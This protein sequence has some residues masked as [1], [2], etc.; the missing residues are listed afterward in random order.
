MA[1]IHQFLA[2]F[3]R[4]D[5]ISNEAV[6]LRS[7]FRSWG[8]ESEIFSEVRRIPPE[9]RGEAR[10]VAEY[11]LQCRSDDVVVLHLSIGSIVNEVF[12]H[13]RCRKAILYHNV[14]PAHYMAP[15][16]KQIAQIL[17]R[18]E[19][20]VKDLAGIA[21]VNMADSRFNADELAEIGYSNVK[22][23]PL[24]LDYSKLSEKPDR[25]VLK[26]FNDDLT[27]ILFVGRCAPNKK[28]ED[29][30][31]AFAYFQRNVNADSRFVHVGSHAGLE[32]YYYALKAMC[33]D[34]KLRNVHFAGTTTQSELNAFYRSADIF[35]CMSEHEGFC[36]PV[37]ESMV[38][39]VPVMAY[40][41]GAVPET[42]DGSGILFD[43]KDFRMIAEMMG[44]LTQ[45]QSLRSSV[46]LGQVERLERYRRRDLA[47]ELRRHL[48]P[49]LQ[50]LN[51]SPRRHQSTKKGSN[52][53]IPP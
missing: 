21:E 49:L 39:N 31:L 2:G 11:E 43:N 5:A 32:R 52:N 19:Q 17:A 8:Y 27:T 3:N 36:I 10:D 18:G 35:L 23:L 34:W 9:L 40:A 22:I 20:Q 38:H 6:T 29:L 50:N 24:V 48:S 45:N 25:K 16:Q 46:L 44:Q 30:L 47:S 1:A 51:Y 26:E 13:L 42:L 14:T 7:L 33:R 53:A 15:V 28:I 37:I 12:L 41:V 4:A